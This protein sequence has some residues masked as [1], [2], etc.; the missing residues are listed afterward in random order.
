LLIRRDF[1]L[2]CGVY[3][4]HLKFT[5][6]VCRL[7]L[8]KVCAHHPQIASA[9]NHTRFSSVFFHFN[10]FQIH[11]SIYTT[12][13]HNCGIVFYAGKE[14]RKKEGKCFS[15]STPPPLPSLMTLS[16]D[17]NSKNSKN[18]QMF[19]TLM[20][21]LF[22]TQSFSFASSSSYYFFNTVFEFS[23]SALTCPLLCRLSSCTCV[24]LFINMIYE[25]ICLPGILASWGPNKEVKHDNLK[26]SESLWTIN[27]S[28]LG[29]DGQKRGNRTYNRC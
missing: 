16:T 5:N 23:S 25:M 3:K 22:N 1:F 14:H 10:Q 17:V 19:L 8:V 28:S 13:Y 15:P 11:I 29:G 24:C 12:L 9:I 21:L 6:C 20:Y 7:R 26:E 18:R 4:S 27:H 2:S